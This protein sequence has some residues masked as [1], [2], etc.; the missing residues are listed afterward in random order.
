VRCCDSAGEQADLFH[1][2][3]W[4]RK[5]Q[6]GKTMELALGLYL[7]DAIIKLHG[8]RLWLNNSPSGGKI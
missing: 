4:A 1:P 3:H 5:Q 6:E 2:L 7:S 8:G